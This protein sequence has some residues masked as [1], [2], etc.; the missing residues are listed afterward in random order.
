MSAALGEHLPGGGRPARHCR[1]DRLLLTL[2]Y[3]REYRTYAHIAQT[4]GLSESAVCRTVHT[5]AAP[6]TRSRTPCCARARSRC[7]ASK[8]LTR[9]DISVR[10]RSSWTRPSARWSVPKKAEARSYSGKKK[11]HTRKA[12]VVADPKTGR[13]LAT[14]FSAG[15]VHDF[16]LFV[17]SRLAL[18][19]ADRV[20][21]GQRLSGAEEAPPVTAG[22]RA[23]RSKLH[24]LTDGA[25]GRQPAALAGTVRGRAY[26]PQRQD[27]PHP[28]GA[29]PQPAQA[30]RPA[31]QPDRRPLQPRA[32]S[33]RLT[34]DI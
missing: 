33:L 18:R 17:Q 22:C 30:V 28:G 20:P 32:A 7:R 15:K 23:K 34:Q 21:G 4:Y 25:E 9:S 29:L 16:R 5:S 26:H 12:Q 31:L 8:V 3:W 1:E 10:G 24:P 27:L 11:G 2:M 19:P 14:A 13:I 6:S